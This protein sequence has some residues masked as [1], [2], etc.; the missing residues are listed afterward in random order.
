MYIVSFRPTYWRI[1]LEALLTSGVKTTF[2][3]FFTSTLIIINYHLQYDNTHCYGGMI[4]S[5]P[6]WTL[7]SC[8]SSLLLSTCCFIPWDSEGSISSCLSSLSKWSEYLCFS[9]VTDPAND[10]LSFRC[11]TY[12]WSWTYVYQILE[13]KIA[14]T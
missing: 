8:A 14:I 7:C 11:S 10:L 1:I 4:F 13:H 3:P 12:D 2:K 6:T 5:L 9:S